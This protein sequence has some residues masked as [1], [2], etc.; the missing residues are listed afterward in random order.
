MTWGVFRTV[1]ETHVMPINDLREHVDLPNCWCRP[2]RDEEEPNLI[3]HNSMDRREFTK[4]KG[5]WQ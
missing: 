4:E 3:V 1:H 2:K 5:K